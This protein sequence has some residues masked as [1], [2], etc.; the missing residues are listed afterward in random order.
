MENARI[1]S[2]SNKGKIGGVR[3]LVRC[4]NCGWRLCDTFA[5]GKL[6]TCELQ[7]GVTPP[8]FPDYITKC[9]RCKKEI[10]IHKKT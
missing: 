8:W 1:H 10:G 2:V 9:G 5:A 6:E 4:P 3:R 7:E